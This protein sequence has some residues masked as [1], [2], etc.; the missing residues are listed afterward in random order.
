MR[1]QASPPSASVPAA[2][3]AAAAAADAI[4]IAIAFLSAVL[5]LLLLL[6]LGAPLL[7]LCMRGPN[8]ACQ[9]YNI[10]MSH[11]IVIKFTPLL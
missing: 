7:G 2:A 8:V 4:A 11:A 3:A 1:V 10:P 9:I 6:L 5:V